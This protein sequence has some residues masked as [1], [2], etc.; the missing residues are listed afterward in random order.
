MT[1]QELR[2]VLVAGLGKNRQVTPVNDL[3]IWPCRGGGLHDRPKL[4]IHLRRTTRNVEGFDRGAVLNDLD[5]PSW[6]Q[7]V[8]D[9]GERALN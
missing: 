7:R 6:E 9:G 5:A 2:Q 3:D 1:G 8:G 4:V